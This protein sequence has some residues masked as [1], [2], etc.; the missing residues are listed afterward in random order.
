MWEGLFKEKI[1]NVVKSS[2]Q[3]RILPH[4][5]VITVESGIDKVIGDTKEL[6]PLDFCILASSGLSSMGQLRL[7]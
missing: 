6:K 3:R 5:R 7:P 2:Y 1:M 4:T